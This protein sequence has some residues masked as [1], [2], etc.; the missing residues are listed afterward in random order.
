M[1]NVQNEGVEELL[2]ELQDRERWWRD[3]YDRAF[4]ADGLPAVHAAISRCKF[5]LLLDI[6]DSRSARAPHRRSYGRKRP[7]RP[8]SSS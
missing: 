8:A 7:Q 3:V 2:R 5:T 1:A 6:P 4:E